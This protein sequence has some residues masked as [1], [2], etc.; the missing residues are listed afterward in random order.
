MVPL[1]EVQFFLQVGLLRI[2]ID[3]ETGQSSAFIDVVPS[4]VALPPDAF[5][6]TEVLFALERLCGLGPRAEH[7]EDQQNQNQGERESRRP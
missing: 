2:G 5:G 1:Q 7:G 3:L 4:Q 6:V